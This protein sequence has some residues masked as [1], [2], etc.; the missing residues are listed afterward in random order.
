VILFLFGLYHFTLDKFI[1]DCY[2]EKL[3]EIM[4]KVQCFLDFSCIVS[5]T[6]LL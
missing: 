1:E 6:S 4:Y 2:F 3:V 5:F